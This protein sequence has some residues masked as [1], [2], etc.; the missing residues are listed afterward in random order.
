MRCE[1]HNASFIKG[2]PNLARGTAQDILQITIAV[3]LRLWSMSCYLQRQ[4]KKTL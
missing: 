1:I 3:P 2:H 4:P